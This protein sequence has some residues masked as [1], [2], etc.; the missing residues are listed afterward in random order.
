MAATTKLAN[1]NKARQLEPAILDLVMHSLT[2]NILV[3][4]LW[5]PSPNFAAKSCTLDT[6]KA[7]S[8]RVFEPIQTLE[9]IQATKTLA[10]PLLDRSCSKLNHH[11]WD[12]FIERNEHSQAY[13]SN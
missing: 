3:M 13:L 7:A 5:L 6:P 2:N 9:V 10:V 12:Q 1:H 11:T 4:P 8:P